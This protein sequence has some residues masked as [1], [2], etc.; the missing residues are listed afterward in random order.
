VSPS[1]YLIPTLALRLTQEFGSGY[2]KSNLK[3][4]RQFYL[5]FPV[6]KSRSIG[7]TLCGQL[8]WSHY[9]TL[10]RVASEKA[11]YW[12]IQEAAAQDRPVRTLIRQITS[13]AYE[14]TLRSEQ[15]ARARKAARKG[16]NAHSNRPREP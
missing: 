14:K 1:Q 3:D 9:R 7:R 15:P 2:G 6:G 13:F 10:M 11:R 4:F 5:A 8:T 12:Y 16:A